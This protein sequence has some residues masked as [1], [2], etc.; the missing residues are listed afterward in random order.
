LLNTPRSE[1]IKERFG[2]LIPAIIDAHRVQTERERR[3]RRKQ[4]A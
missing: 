4:R 1:E 3:A 2:A